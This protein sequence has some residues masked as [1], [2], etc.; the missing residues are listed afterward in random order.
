MEPV[1]QPSPEL[2]IAQTIDRGGLIPITPDQNP[3]YRREASVRCFS[4]T[5]PAGTPGA[6]SLRGRS[7]APEDWDRFV[8]PEGQVYFRRRSNPIVLTESSICKP[9]VLEKLNDW[10]AMLVDWAAELGQ[11]L[12]ESVH[13]WAHLSEDQES[14]FYCFVDHARHSVFWLEE[15][16]SDQLGIERTASIHHLAHSFEEQYWLHVEHFP[17][18]IAYVAE[19]IL[20]NVIN[21]FI[22][23]CGDLL[24]SPNSAFPYNLKDA[25]D[26]LNLLHGC[27]SRLSDQHVIWAIARVTAIISGWRRTVHYGEEHAR[28]SYD[29]DIVKCSVPQRNI[30][31]RT[32]GFAVCNLQEQYYSKLE[33]I[34]HND[35]VS[36]RCWPL[37]RSDLMDDWSHWMKLSFGLLIANVLMLPV[38]WSPAVTLSSILF[39]TASVSMALVLSQHLS[40]I[41]YKHAWHYLYSRRRRYGFMPLA[42]AFSLPK[43][44]F[45]YGL[46]TFIAQAVCMVFRFFNPAQIPIVALVAGAVIAFL[47]TA[48]SVA[49][50]PS[51]FDMAADEA[52]LAEDDEEAAC[53][54]GDD[55]LTVYE[56]EPAPTLA[57]RIEQWLR[58]AIKERHFSFKSHKG[59]DMVGDIEK[60]D[61]YLLPVAEIDQKLAAYTLPY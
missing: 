33:D 10:I 9:D 27:R 50:Q 22:H 23:G 37:F 48:V 24:T 25:Q 43:A 31:L 55:G 21:V 13:I 38:S 12:S 58:G 19:E 20:D 3:R 6:P 39:S 60:G 41:A 2:Q 36:Q 53:E 15:C 30:C 32:L 35:S 5:V 44:F 16:S 57:Q 29:Q 4:W 17:M 45:A 42:L 8:H 18:G 7:D 56:P 40:P 14:C 11:D 28:L 47:A 61:A 34:F 51:K 26:I 49:L 54:D 52:A 46:A 1:E 59:I